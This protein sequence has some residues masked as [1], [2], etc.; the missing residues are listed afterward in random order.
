MAERTDEELIHVLLHALTEEELAPA[1]EAARSQKEV[2]DALS[3]LA[4]FDLTEDE[5][6]RGIRALGEGGDA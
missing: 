3:T 2:Y 4:Y 5:F 6:T 1:I